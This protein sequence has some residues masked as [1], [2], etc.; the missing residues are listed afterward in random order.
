MRTKLLYVVSTIAPNITVDAAT[1][2]A[3]N[4]T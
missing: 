1:P 3:M 4:S 2:G